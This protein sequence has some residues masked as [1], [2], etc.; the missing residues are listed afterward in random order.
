MMINQTHPNL[1]WCPSGYVMGLIERRKQEFDR[2]QGIEKRYRH[3]RAPP[4]RR[5]PD[6]S[7]DPRRHG[8]GHG[9][10]LPGRSTAAGRVPGR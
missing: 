9:G 4:L 8:G 6:R 2:I 7:R 3:P 10:P 1:W 5:G